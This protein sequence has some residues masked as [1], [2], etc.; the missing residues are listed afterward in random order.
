MEHC[1]LDHTIK[2]LPR[3]EPKLSKVYLLSPVEQKKLDIFLK[4]N[5]HTRQ[6]RPS[7]SSI[8]TL[9]FFIKK[10]DSFLYLV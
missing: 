5:L 3:L 2:L 4:G 8:A 10:K 6:T 7:E 1:H 9:V